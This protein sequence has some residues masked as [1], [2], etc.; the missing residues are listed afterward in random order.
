MKNPVKIFGIQDKGFIKEGFDA[1]FTIVDMNKKL[2]L[3]MKILK[4]NVVGHL[5]MD[6]NLKAHQYQR[7][8]MVKLK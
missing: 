4:V 1:D 2:Q 3:K 7:S 6:M 8:L 5:L